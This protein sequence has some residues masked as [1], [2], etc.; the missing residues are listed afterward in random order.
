MVGRPPRTLRAMH[1]PTRLLASAVAVLAGA[2]LLVAGGAA[3][4]SAAPQAAA[5]P[6]GVL[7][8][9]VQAAGRNDARAMWSL[10]SSQTQKRLGPD[11]AAFT[12]LNAPGFH[13]AVGAFTH[14]GSFTVRLSQKLSAQWAIAVITGQR[15]VQSNPQAGAFGVA[16]RGEGATW[17]LE[18]GGPIALRIL[19]PK[20]GEIVRQPEPQM[21]VEAKAKAEIL[22]GLLYADGAAV[23]A[24]AGG[25]DPRTLTFFGPAPTIKSTGVHYGAAIVATRTD[26]AAVAWTFGF[27]PTKA[28]T[29]LPPGVTPPK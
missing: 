21:A 15:I 1:R 24:S 26:A 25:T 28:I 16:L 4:A 27:V 10:L 20:E 13:D 11:L 7:T 19:G 14:D 2:A 23:K 29:T 17:K 22:G 3:A 8:A 6:G 9:F 18:L 5:T 12:R